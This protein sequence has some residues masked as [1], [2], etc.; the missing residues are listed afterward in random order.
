MGDQNNKGTIAI[1]SVRNFYWNQKKCFVIL[2]KNIKFYFYC[3]N[4][5]PDHFY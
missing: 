3:I 2:Y 1:D 4:L 5:E